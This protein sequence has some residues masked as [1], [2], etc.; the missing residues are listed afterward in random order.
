[1]VTSRI[2]WISGG[3]HRKDK[4]FERHPNRAAATDRTDCQAGGRG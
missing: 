3:S 2:S 4:A 1:M